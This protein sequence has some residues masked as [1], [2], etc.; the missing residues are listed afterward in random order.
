MLRSPNDMATSLNCCAAP[1]AEPI[2]R[3]GRRTSRLDNGAMMK[4]TRMCQDVGV[5]RAVLLAVVAVLASGPTAEACKL[6]SNPPHSVEPG[7]QAVDHVPPSAPIVRVAQVK[8]GHDT[9]P[10]ACGGSASDCDGTGVVE[11][12]V[13]AQDD[14]STADRLGYRVQLVSGSL[15][16]GLSIPAAPV[17]PL[18]SPDKVASRRLIFSWDDR[19][20]GHHSLGFTLAVAAIDLAGNASEPVQVE[21][22]DD[23]GAG[24]Q[25]GTTSRTRWD[26]PVPVFALIGLF[27]WTRRRITAL[28]SALQGSE[29]RDQ[30]DSPS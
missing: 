1:P 12:E 24:C 5:S 22:S 11:L 23:D 19:T 16:E 21:V 2:R 8:R 27:I 18:L 9:S 15:P 14:R 13:A 3:R 6:V 28:T 10:G 20:T 7:E 29:M 17:R 30:E 26:A 25:V 4:S